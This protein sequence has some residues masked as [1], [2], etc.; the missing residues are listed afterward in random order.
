MEYYERRIFSDK[1]DLYAYLE[2]R[3]DREVYA[4]RTTDIAAIETGLEENVKTYLIMSPTIYG[5]GTGLFN[6]KSIQLPAIIRTAI[7]K[8]QVDVVGDGTGAWDA[9]HIQ[10]LAPLYELLLVKVLQVED[11]PSGKQGIFF[12]ETGDFT[13]MQLAQ[14]LANELHRQG[15]LKTA[16][17]KH[18]TLQE[19][20]EQWGNGSPQYAELGFASK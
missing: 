18:L 10:D 20:A 14:G 6:K 15:I 17:V 19:A 8:G 7:K 12:S 9:V 3:E 11:V 1:D 4:Q 2:M 16:D 5:I 13:W